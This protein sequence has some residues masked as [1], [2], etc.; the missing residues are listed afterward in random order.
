MPTSSERL[1]QIGNDHFNRGHYTDAFAWYQRALDC[2]RKTGDQR[3]LLTT[4]GNLG[5]ICAVSGRREQATSF[6]QEVLELQK[7]LGDERGIGVTLV[8][9]GN[10][11]ADAG[12]W[13][14][15]RAYYLEGQDILHRVGG[16]E[17][18]LAV[19]HSD[20]GLIARETGDLDEAMCQYE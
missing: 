6:Y 1:N 7:R 10:L 2:D 18:A 8:N 15:A 4:L 20:L 17:Q 9:L 19:L 13:D 11:H 12:H 14:R 16:D 3:A 5:N